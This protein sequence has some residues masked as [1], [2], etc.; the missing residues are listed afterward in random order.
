MKLNLIAVALL[1]LP[2][3]CST[4]KIT[5]RWKAPGVTPIS[6]YRD[7]LVLVVAGEEDKTLISK[8]EKHMA[9]DFVLMG[10]SA[11][12]ALSE[13]GPGALKGLNE[14]AIVAKFQERGI[15]AILLVSLLNKQKEKYYVPGRMQQTPYADY[16]DRF[17]RHY[18]VMMERIVTPGYYSFDT[19][20]FWECSFYEARSGKL[21]YSAISESFDPQSLES[22]A[23]QFGSR[24]VSDMVKEKVIVDKIDKAGF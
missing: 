8:M 10:Y 13:F 18:D 20:Y 6:A 4:T 24:M 14:S 2:A 21:L 19:R 15:D 5:S 23:H 16:Y 7:I 9:G 1:L 22:L 11:Y 12:S 17:P 3:A